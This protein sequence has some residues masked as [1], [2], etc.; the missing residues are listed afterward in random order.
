M[1]L[2]VTYLFT[3]H[4]TSSTA[5]S[6]LAVYL[7]TFITVYNNNACPHYCSHTIPIHFIAWCPNTIDY[8]H[9]LSARNDSRPLVIF[10]P[11]SVVTIFPVHF[12]WNNNQ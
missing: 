8:T 11:I 3:G 6:R 4:M 7:A 5:V 12:Q 1:S 9:A 10:K 2:V